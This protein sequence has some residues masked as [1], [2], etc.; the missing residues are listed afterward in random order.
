LF[1]CSKISCYVAVL[2][3]SS[4]R[5]ER[6][7]LPLSQ[8]PV[9]PTQSSV[10]GRTAGAAWAPAPSPALYSQNVT[11]PSAAANLLQSIAKAIRTASS[12]QLS[13]GPDRSGRQQS[14]AHKRSRI[15]QCAITPVRYAVKPTETKVTVRSPRS[16]ESVRTVTT[17]ASRVRLPR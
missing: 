16:R 8:P 9:S 2:A 10:S 5:C 12:G 7:A 6:G 3:G 11:N 17:L 14:F 1:S 13:I 15:S 4:L